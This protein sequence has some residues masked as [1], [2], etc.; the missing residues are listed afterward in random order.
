[1]KNYCE[2]CSYYENRYYGEG[3]WSDECTYKLN[4]EPY[5]TFLQRKYTRYNPV[6]SIH[7]ANNDCKYYKEKWFRKLLRRLKNDQSNRTEPE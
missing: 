7:N 2:N 5:D 4:E 1:M 6:P 3:Y